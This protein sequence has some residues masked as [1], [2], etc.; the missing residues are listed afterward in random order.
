MSASFS[1]PLIAASRR[2]SATHRNVAQFRRARRQH[3]ERRL[4]LEHLEDRRLLSVFVVTGIG[5]EHLSSLPNPIP[6]TLELPSLRAAVEAAN[7][8]SGEDI[9]RFAPNLA[10]NT[11]TLTL[12]ELNLTEEWTTTTIEG[13]GREQLTIDGNHSSRVFR[14]RPAV[15]A[16]I[17]GLTIAHGRSTDLYGGGSIYN[18]GILTITDCTISESTS[19]STDYNYGGGGIY[20]A[21]LLTVANS[22]LSKNS[23]PGKGGG[24]YNDQWATLTVTNCTL[25]ENSA[26]GYGG[27]IYDR[28][29]GK[30]TITNCVFAMNSSPHG[31]GGAF[32]TNEASS[33]TLA[34]STLSGNWTDGGYG[35][36][37]EASYSTLTVTNS[38]LTGNRA[39]WGGGIYK[40]QGTL[41]VANSTLS[42]NASAWGGGGIHIMQA[43]AQL[44]NSTLAGNSSTSIGGAGIYHQGTSLTVTNSTL[45]GNSTPW[46]GGAIAVISGAVTLNNTIVAD[47]T[48][49]DNVEISGAVTANY[50]LIDSAAGATISG[51]GYIVGQAAQLGPLANH[52]GP[53]QTMPLLPGSPAIDAGSNSLIPSGVETDRRGTGFARLSTGMATAQQRWIWGPTSSCRLGHRWPPRR[54]PERHRGPSG[55]IRRNGFFR[56]GWRP[57]ELRLGFRRRHDRHGPHAHTRLCRQRQLHRVVDGGRRPRQHGDR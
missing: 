56:S 47:N 11:I 45:A 54:G 33:A 8:H 35:G 52:G 28:Y 24:I 37:I 32:Y 18:T 55:A 16:N 31:G 7:T 9:I 49:R 27:G 50:S 57:P 23:T 12:G 13:L 40:Y 19:T 39:Q 51:T 14:I 26:E 21:G 41:V 6:D 1:S 3:R 48:A 22:T 43:A 30:L 4:F 29:R 38:T 20:N 5:D 25:T 17:S 15:T 42:A 44:T 46:F 2:P 36:A 10:G 53:T 34:N